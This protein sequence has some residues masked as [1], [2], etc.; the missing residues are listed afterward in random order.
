MQII[1]PA[2]HTAV[3]AAIE[4]AANKALALDSMAQRKLATLAGKVFHIEC[5][6][7]PLDLYIKPEEEQLSLSGF[8]D[9]P[10]TTAIKGTGS[11]YAKLLQ[12]DDPAGVLINEPF[13]LTGDSAPLIELQK[14][15]TQLELDWEAP[16]VDT[17]GDVVGHQL[18]ERLRDFF[19]WSEQAHKSLLRQASDFI[20]QEARFAP[21]RVEVEKFFRDNSQLSQQVDR[22]DARMRKLKQRIDT[23][24]ADK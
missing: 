7:P 15:I 24:K 14:I 10:I 9:G 11:D 6:N 8:Y 3:T 1:D 19:S 2:L 13:V 16:L 5:S 21:S 20:Q 22:L 17:F 4:V 12:S 23:L 18:A